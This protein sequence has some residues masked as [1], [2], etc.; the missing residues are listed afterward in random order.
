MALDKAQK[1]AARLCRA[2]G[3][4]I[5]VDGTVCGGS[6]LSDIRYLESRGRK[7]LAVS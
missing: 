4:T 7:L 6:F 2:A 3:V 1:N 5:R